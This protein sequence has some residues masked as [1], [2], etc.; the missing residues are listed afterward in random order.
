MKMR[1]YNRITPKER[2]QIELL[3]RKHQGYS[4]IAKA[5]NRPRCTIKREIDRGLYFNTGYYIAEH[6]QMI[7]DIKKRCKRVDPKLLINRPLLFYVYRGL[8]NGLT[9]DQISNRIKLDYPDNAL[10][11]ISHE[12]IYVYIYQRTKPKLRSKLIALLPQSRPVRQGKSKRYI[13][14]GV[15]RD[16]VPIDERPK[17]IEDRIEVG[18]WESDLIIGKG[19]GSC[20]GTIVERKSRFSLI[21]ALE[22]KK[23]KHVVKAFSKAL[24]ELPKQLLKTITHDNG[25][26]MAA[27]KLLAK[28]TGMAVYFAH[29]YS[30]WERGTNENTN[31]LIRRVF[32]KKTDFNDVAAAD[33][34]AL[35]DN[36][37]NR[38][39]KVLGYKT[40]KEV[41]AE[42]CA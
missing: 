2:C 17:E 41:L 39:R 23:S 7:A 9:P 25:V 38:P 11:R 8:L 10:M 32:P 37:N 6:A 42:L 4:E 21:I 19:Q 40:P 27:H 18:H 22:S 16:R 24:L 30:S 20:I 28:W 13:Y 5:L 36:L 26:E 31:G 14:R 34:K 1:D 29:P 3:Y 15:I 35:Q 12:S 33:L